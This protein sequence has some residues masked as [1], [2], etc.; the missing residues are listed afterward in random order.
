MTQNLKRSIQLK[1]NLTEEEA[2]LL[3][4]LAKQSHLNKSDYVRA[5]LFEVEIPIQEMSTD[6][7]KS[8]C[9][10]L[11]SVNKIERQY[12]DL[13]NVHEIHTMKKELFQL[14]HM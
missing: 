9:I 5:K 7:Y 1:T 2:H 11:D 10:M 12:P 6:V 3:T 8:L 14:C 4:T 13:C